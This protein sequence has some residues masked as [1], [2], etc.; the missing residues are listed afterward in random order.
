MKDKIKNNENYLMKIPV[1]GYILKKI[2]KNQ[3]E[4]ETTFKT[5]KEVGGETKKRSFLGI[6]KIISGK[7]FNVLKLKNRNKGS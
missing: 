3:P 1:L 4:I 7:T 6:L 2:K 5:G